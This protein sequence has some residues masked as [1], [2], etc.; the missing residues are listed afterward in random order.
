M[1]TRQARTLVLARNATRPGRIVPEAAVRQQLDDLDRSMRRGLEGEGLAAVHI[2]R[3]AED[4]DA[5]EV[6][7]RP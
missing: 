1:T 3:A 2:L 5:L 7:W 6:A 4:V